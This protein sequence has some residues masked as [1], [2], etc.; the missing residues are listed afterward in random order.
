MKKFLFTVFATLTIFLLTTSKAEA[1][2][3]PVLLNKDLN[4]TVEDMFYEKDAGEDF[5]L[6]E[7]YVLKAYED[8]DESFK[9][10]HEH[11]FT[12]E[13]RSL[14]WMQF[15][16]EEG[17]EMAIKGTNLISPSGDHFSIPAKDFYL[18]EIF[19]AGEWKVD[20]EDGV[21]SV[22]KAEIKRLKTPFVEEVEFI[23]PE[24]DFEYYL[25]EFESFIN[26]GG[27][28]IIYN[29]EAYEYFQ[30]QKEKK[31]VESLDDRKLSK[32]D[33]ILDNYYQEGDEVV[34]ISTN[35]VGEVVT[36]Y[37]NLTLAILFEGGAGR[38]N[39]LVFNPLVFSLEEEEIA[40]VVDNFEKKPFEV[41]LDEGADK[42]LFVLFVV[43]AILGVLLIYLTFT[44]IFRALFTEEKKF[45]F[46]MHFE[47]TVGFWKSFLIF[48]NLIVMI[49]GSGVY[50]LARKYKENTLHEKLYQSIETFLEFLESYIGVGEAS[51]LLL[52]FVV[53]ILTINAIVLS[54]LKWDLIIATR[55]KFVNKLNDLLPQWSKKFILKSGRYVGLLLVV[56]IITNAIVSFLPIFLNY[57]L[58]CLTVLLFTLYFIVSRQKKSKKEKGLEKFFKVII[59]MLPSFLFLSIIFKH[60]TPFGI[61]K[62]FTTTFIDIGKVGAPFELGRVGNRYDLT[63]T[64]KF[65][66]SDTKTRMY[67]RLRTNGEV[68][69]SLT[70]ESLDENIGPGLFFD[71]D[72][73]KF[74]K[75]GNIGNL[76]IYAQESFKVND[77]LETTIDA[78]KK[79]GI[80]KYSFVFNSYDP[81]EKRLILRNYLK[82]DMK[83][84]FETKTY[85]LS[86]K[87]AI[88]FYTILDNELDLQLDFEDANEQLGRDEFII[89]VEDASG[90]VV[91]SKYREDDGKY[92][93]EAKTEES[94]KLSEEGLEEGIYRIIISG[95]DIGTDYSDVGSDITFNTL[96]LNSSKLVVSSIESGQLS[97]EET[98]NLFFKPM[99]E[100]I[101]K[102]ISLETDDIVKYD[103]RVL[104]A[105]STEGSK[106]RYLKSDVE[107][108][109]I[110]HEKIER[111]TLACPQETI[112][113]SYN[114]YSF[115]E[116]SYF[117]PFK[118]FFTEVDEVDKTVFSLSDLEVS[119]TGDGWYESILYLEG[120][121]YDFGKPININLDSSFVYDN[122]YGNTSLYEF[123][124]D[125]SSHK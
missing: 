14:I 61:N 64:P 29:N 57:T 91:A 50:W 23:G 33:V 88:V 52:A 56:I 115:D 72:F 28:A 90:N 13:G 17:R 4:E 20:I 107:S 123:S 39:V 43:T 1:K 112:R 63:F 92:V 67:Q 10:K 22:Y 18:M 12:T 60:I 40:E 30:I 45:D 16:N 44:D 66:E 49:A 96:K 93:Y 5:Q 89:R 3:E 6:N 55:D 77:S 9:F 116:G 24:L 36:R 41:A 86:T 122:K 58:I 26:S 105:N 99:E 70:G 113:S 109:E 38:G 98:K 102:N 118:Y 124:L 7:E 119:E 27:N 8:L 83:A 80:D 42:F 120:V 111:V 84:K 117:Y 68:N 74:K 62:T 71:K 95:I 54:M 79:I 25:D 78:G 103:C 31:L 108:F 125:I 46:R 48:L 32:I 19:E 47:D 121:D 59:F 53:I 106:S 81:E 2:Q 11:V 37:K 87:G 97:F 100:H 82:E 104:G 51:S 15:E 21:S 73:V 69:Y 65:S 94:I 76:Y 110:N 85:N 114:F 101:T 35:D 34:S 75:Q